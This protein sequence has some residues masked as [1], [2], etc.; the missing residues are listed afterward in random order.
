MCGMNEPLPLHIARLRSQTAELSA[1]VRQLRK[2]GLDNAPA[3]VLL[4][5][6]RAEL[7]VLLRHAAGPGRS[8]AAGPSNGG[9][10]RPDR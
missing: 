3:E 7:E 8:Q 6:K 2:A 1:A 5:R 4:A 10:R 9:D